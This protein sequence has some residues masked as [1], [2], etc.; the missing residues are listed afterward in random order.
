MAEEDKTDKSTETDNPL[1]DL[2]PKNAVR[3]RKAV[4]IFQPALFLRSL[5]I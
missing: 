5:M 4:R 1:P 3:A 2:E